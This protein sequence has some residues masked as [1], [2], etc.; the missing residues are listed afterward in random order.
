MVRT[1]G[2]EQSDNEDNFGYAESVIPR[3]YILKITYE[4]KDKNKN[5]ALIIIPLQDKMMIG[6]RSP[7]QSM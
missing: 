2:G 5:L 1:R 4:V 3:G 7:K 6:M